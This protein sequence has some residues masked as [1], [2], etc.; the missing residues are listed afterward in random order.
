[1]TPHQILIVAIRLLV[2]FWF[3]SGLVPKHRP[4]GDLG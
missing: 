4:S 1:M 2:V 3:L